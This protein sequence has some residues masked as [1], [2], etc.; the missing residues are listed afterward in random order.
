MPGIQDIY[1]VNVS[2]RYDIS[3]LNNTEEDD[4]NEAAADYDPLDALKNLEDEKKRAQEEAKKKKLASGSKGKTTRKVP[5]FQEIKES[6]V[7]PKKECE[8]S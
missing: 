8:Y 3:Y 7:P 5:K 4:E 1:S 2:N 6:N